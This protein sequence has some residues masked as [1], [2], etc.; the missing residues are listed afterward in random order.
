MAFHIDE[1]KCEVCQ[2][3]SDDLG[4]RI[5]EAD[6]DLLVRRVAESTQRALRDSK[7]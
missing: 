2:A 3:N 4:K 1:M 5:R 7:S 6:L